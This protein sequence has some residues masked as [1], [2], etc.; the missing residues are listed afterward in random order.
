MPAKGKHG[1]TYKK[2]RLQAPRMPACFIYLNY[3]NMKNFFRALAALMLL[4][5]FAVAQFSLSGTVADAETRE[6]LTAAS[7]QLLPLN[8]ATTT[9]QSGHFTY[10]NLPAGSYLLKV[11]YV[12]FETISKTVELSGIW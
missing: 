3:N 12:G 11:S 4:P 6:G 2:S 9:N 7:I 10:S 5:A 1:K 8:Q